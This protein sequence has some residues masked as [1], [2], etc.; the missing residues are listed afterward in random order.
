MILCF[1]LLFY[2]VYR[3]DIFCKAFYLYQAGRGNHPGLWGKRSPRSVASIA[4][5][6]R[7]VVIQHALS[8][9]IR[10][11]LLFHPRLCSFRAS[12]NWWPLSRS[13][14][15]CRNTVWVKALRR[16]AVPGSCSPGLAA[17][18]Q[19][20]PNQKLALRRIHGQSTIHGL[21]DVPLSHPFWV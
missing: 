17:A 16:S 4:T 12:G 11:T 3:G 14:E 7:N 15:H 20:H 5:V 9:G 21:A 1:V 6:C 2:T 13:A 18:T 8:C 19:S 10:I